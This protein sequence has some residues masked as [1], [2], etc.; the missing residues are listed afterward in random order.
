MKELTTT[1][2]QW[3][4]TVPHSARERII[5][6]VN[7]EIR[8][9]NALEMEEEVMLPSPFLRRVMIARAEGFKI[10]Y[11]RGICT[12]AGFGILLA[13]LCV[14]ITAFIGP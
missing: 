3:P 2:I 7:E 4:V 5:H 12:G 6:F 10:G 11:N 14:L 13:A 8:R 1:S 9:Q